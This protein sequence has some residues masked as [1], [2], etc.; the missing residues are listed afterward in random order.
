MKEYTS[1][2]IC[3]WWS[4]CPCQHV[5]FRMIKCDARFLCWCQTGLGSA[6]LGFFNWT[7]CSFS[8]MRFF[9]VFCAQ[10]FYNKYNLSLSVHWTN[11][12]ILSCLDLSIHMH[13]SHAVHD[14][15]YHVKKQLALI[16]LPSSLKFSDS[17]TVSFLFSFSVGAF[18][19]QRFWNPF[20]I[21]PY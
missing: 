18:F 10:I 15:V 3:H 16:F 4:R 11:G 14:L 5:C 12:L 7:I 9:Y 6:R 13:H 21:M 20:Q 17:V 2:S 8:S 1:S 19:I